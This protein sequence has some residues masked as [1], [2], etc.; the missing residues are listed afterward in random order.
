MKRIYL[1]YLI[2]RFNQQDQIIKNKI[3]YQIIDFH[4]N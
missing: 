3:N 4:L 2:D 1:K